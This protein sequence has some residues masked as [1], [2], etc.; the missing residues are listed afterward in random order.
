MAQRKKIALVGA[1]NIGGE[2][3]SL[4]ARK[5]LGD[6][7]LLDIPDKAGVAKGKALDIS[8]ALAL[9]NVD[10]NI[11]GTSDYADIAN[12]DVVIVT[13]GVP[14]KPG[15]SRDDLLSI[16]LK[17][18]RSV[19]AGIKANAP[20][21]FVIV[22]SNPV[23]AMVDAM[24]KATEFPANRVI[25][26]AGVL[27]ASRFSHFLALEM[28]VSPKEIQTLV[29]GNHGDLMVPTISYCTVNGIP[30]SQF[31]SK[32]RLDAI[33]ERT[34]KGGG[35][36]VELMGT[37]AYVAPASAGIAMAASYLLDQKRLIPCVAKCSGE[38]GVNDLY[39]GVPVIVGAGG[40][41]KIVEVA[42]TDSEKQQMTASADKVREQ[43][44]ASARL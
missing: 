22:I 16:N 39:L 21:A 18:I 36:I 1:G 20:N 11:L 10:A 40:V 15:M 4:A 12:A 3:A 28:N 37:S 13:A 7:V 43:I 14:R 24:Q 9:E 5:E 27:D 17:I 34:K 44:E 38:Y 2:L 19:A 42:L 26:M 30:V 6:V 41:E 29:L 35:E 33:I 8:Q 23:D 25:G 31:I 32:E